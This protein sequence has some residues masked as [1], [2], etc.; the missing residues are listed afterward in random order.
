MTGR[1]LV[2][3]C[4]DTKS[5]DLHKM[6][7]EWQQP[8]VV[9][10]LLACGAPAANAFLLYHEQNTT[11]TYNLR[12][13]YQITITRIARSLYYNRQITMLETVF[14]GWACTNDLQISSACRYS[15]IIVHGN[16]SQ[17]RKA[18]FCHNRSC[19]CLEILLIKEKDRSASALDISNVQPT[20]SRK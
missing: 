12:S 4:P 19:V 15:F 10:H 17:I 9:M 3:A 2:A 16:Q 13:I 20:T 5:V 1:V 7:R 18:F 14:L 6:D 11:V 8:E